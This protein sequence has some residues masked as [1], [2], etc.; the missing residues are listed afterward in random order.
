MCSIL[1]H[2]KF[3]GYCFFDIVNGLF[4]SSAKSSCCFSASDFSV[5][6]YFYERIFIY[7]KILR[8]SSRN[9]KLTVAFL[10]VFRDQVGS[11]P[12]PP[13]PEPA[14]AKSGTALVGWI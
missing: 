10:F 2:E 3:I 9:K 8:F 13:L 11:Q 14:M 6:N 1:F 7:L 4:L 12:F 5:L